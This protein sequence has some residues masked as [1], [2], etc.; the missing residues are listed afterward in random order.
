[1]T[2]QIY[3]FAFAVG[4]IV[5]P[6]IIIPVRRDRKYDNYP[7]ALNYLDNNMLLVIYDK[8]H[9]SAGYFKG[10]K[11]RRARLV[12]VNGSRKDLG[13]MLKVTHVLS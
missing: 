6:I 3:S 5:I 4:G 8:L 1:M 13:E 11:V 12:N 2:Y 9:T 10:F 7:Y